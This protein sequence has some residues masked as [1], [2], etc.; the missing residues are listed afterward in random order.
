MLTRWALNELA[1]LENQKIKDKWCL[2]SQKMQKSEV[3]SVATSNS[4]VDARTMVMPPS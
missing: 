4:V 1:H 2:M 3:Q